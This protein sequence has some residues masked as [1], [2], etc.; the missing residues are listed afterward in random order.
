VIE[1][2]L[3]IVLHVLGASVWV[4]GHLV[5]ATTILPRALRDDDPTA[6]QSFEQAFERIGVPALLLQVATG[7]R[8]A[9]FYAPPSR[10]LS[11]DDH[12]SRHVALKLG[13][14][15]A[16]IALA[17]H[18]RISLVPRLSSG[19]PLRNLAGHIVLVT[20]LAVAF[21]VVGVSLRVGGL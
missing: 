16:T 7:L 5:L 15:A 21:A 14:L 6:I 11:F 17:A 4:G 13:C 2:N 20:L 3:L 19:A 9:A 18:A 1:R 8:L 10:W 12:A